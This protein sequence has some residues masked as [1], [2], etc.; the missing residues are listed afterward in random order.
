MK[1]RTA[2]KVELWML[3]SRLPGEQVASE[4]GIKDMLDMLNQKYVVD[5]ERQKILCLDEFFRV[6]RGKEESV[7][8]FVS[9]FNVMS[10]KMSSSR[11]GEHKRG[12]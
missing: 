10:C 9:R 2:L 7:K 12:V 8:D 11:K 1:L 3:V 6:K 4:G 5:M